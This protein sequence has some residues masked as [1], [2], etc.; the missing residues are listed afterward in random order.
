MGLICILVMM[1]QKNWSST[2]ITFIFPVRMNGLKTAS[3]LQ[4]G[5]GPGKKPCDTYTRRER[6]VRR[7][8]LY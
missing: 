4:K 3:C 5:R 8:A 6:S 2:V 7:L 1:G